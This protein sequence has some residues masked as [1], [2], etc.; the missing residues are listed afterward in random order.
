[1]TVKIIS[2]SSCDL[3]KKTLEELQIEVLKIKN[4]D[5][6][7]KDLPENITNKEIYRKMR[8]GKYFKTSKITYYEYYKKFE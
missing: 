4:T 6:D 8:E 3:D 7:H 5:E 1:M 2:D